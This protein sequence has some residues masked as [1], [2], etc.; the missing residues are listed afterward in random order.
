MVLEFEEKNWN[1]TG[2]SVK[3]EFIKEIERTYFEFLTVNFESRQGAKQI[4]ETVIS[5]ATYRRKTN[6][7][8]ALTCLYFVIF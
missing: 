7:T 1:I 3:S 2:N 6:V 4:K 5:N 8:Q